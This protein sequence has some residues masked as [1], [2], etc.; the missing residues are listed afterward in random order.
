[1][2][3]QNVVQ[4]RLYLQHEHCD[5]PHLL[6]LQLTKLSTAGGA[7]S[8]PCGSRTTS[9]TFPVTSHPCCLGSR[10]GGA[11]FPAAFYNAV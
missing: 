7:I 8:C 2:H 4:V 11:A 1:M 9:N 10:S 3:L 6:Q 5:E